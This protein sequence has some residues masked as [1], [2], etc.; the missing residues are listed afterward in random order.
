MGFFV[1]SLLTVVVFGVTGSI[2]S[3]AAAGH[4]LLINEFYYDH[5]GKDD[6]REY[7]E[8]INNSPAPVIV[9]GVSLE[10]HNG[11][12]DDGWVTLWEGTAADT[13][14]PGGLFV[15]GGADVT[16]TPDALVELRLQN[17]PDA[18]RLTE[19]GIPA[20]MVGY[21][22]LD[23]EAYVEG[24]SASGVPAGYSLGRL[25][26][27][28]DTDDNAADYRQMTP[29]PGLFNV[30]R[31]EVTLAPAPSTPVG[32]VLDEDGFED[33]D[34]RLCNN[35]LHVIPAGA[36]TVEVWDSTSTSVHLCEQLSNI[37]SI[38][39]EACADLSASL[40]LW[41]GHHW[42]IV[43]VFYGP[44]ERP[45]N[46]T[47]ELLRRVGGPRLVVSE[48]LSYPRGEC[49]Q[50][51]ELYNAGLEAEFIRGCKLRDKSHSPAVVTV[52]SIAVP[53]GGLLV[54]T[55][56]KVSILSYFPN[57]P[58]EC[59]V[60]HE[61]SWPTFNRSGSG[62]VSDS[63]VFMDAFSLPIDAVG[64]P[65]VGSEDRGRSLERVDLY[66]GPP[67][68]TWVLSNDPS[69]ASPGRP[70]DRALFAPPPVG[71]VAIA[72]NPFSP[73]DGSTATISVNPSMPDVRAVISVF[74]VNGRKLS[75]LGSATHFP[76]VFI[77]TG[78]DA[79]GRLLPPGLYVVTCEL[80]TLSG[81]SVVTE[82]VVV[83]CGRRDA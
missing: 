10:F 44:D 75:D 62:S 30:P 26:D 52:D 55:P 78:T 39:P 73:Y 48:V 65:P 3:V 45:H 32:R 4:G 61:G 6:G 59:L 58:P 83:G 54:V 20:D 23:D 27:G 33:I 35:G 7:I 51:V 50:F 79:D 15:V 74:D 43:R 12:G 80:F 14:A 71:S 57:L 76:A 46:N 2:A 18:I 29:S 41:F 19:N 11:A 9:A 40:S 24:R 37:G 28:S 16:P 36:L 31:H 42:I 68:P 21:G 22:G 81:E 13:V 8:I 66:S 72:P 17:G 34:L 25:P 77:W 70:G 64:Y 5:P 56:D 49:P 38:Q 53:P 67:S 60:E 82:K 63:V 1:C 69:G 47:I